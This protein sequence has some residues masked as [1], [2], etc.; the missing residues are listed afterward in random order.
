MPNHTTNHLTI[1]GPASY[2][3]EMKK[4]VT[5]NETP[6]S[7]NAIIPM[8]EELVN[9]IKGYRRTNNET[10]EETS[11]RE[12]SEASL[13]ETFGADNWYD[14]SIDNWGTK[15]DVYP[16]GDTLE[17]DD[18]SECEVRIEFLSAWAPPLPVIKALAVRFP[19]LIFTINYT[20]EGDDYA[21]QIIYEGDSVYDD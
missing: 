12:L 2:I 5:D 16:T 4:F 10:P 11:K 18:V 17:W 14:W 13:R 9:T 21:K 8:P 20:D 19:N 1:T 7:C 6:F 3:E 15:W